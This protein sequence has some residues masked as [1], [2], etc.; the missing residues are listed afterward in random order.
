M[1]KI[2]ISKEAEVVLKGISKIFSGIIIRDDY[3]YT[4]FVADVEDKSSKGTSNIVV[5]YKLPVGGLVTPQHFG[6][7]DINKF[8]TVVNSFEKESTNITMSGNVLNIKDKRKKVK[9][10]TQTTESLPVKNS[11]GDALWE[12]G[13]NIITFALTEGEREKIKSDLSVLD[14][15]TISLKGEGNKL[16]IVASNNITGNSTDIEIEA[17]FVGKAEGE[18]V[19]PNSE[20]FDV[21]M[22]STYKVEVRD[23]KHGE[24][25]IKICKFKSA[26]IVGLEYTLVVA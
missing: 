17:Q 7:S 20:I 24:K 6:I 10:F 18:F 19:F 4:K 1:S 12:A 26:D 8:L 22:N 5:E 23:C 9:Y 21:I 15:N 13:T 16:N 2:E 14:I 25:I 11:A 3:L